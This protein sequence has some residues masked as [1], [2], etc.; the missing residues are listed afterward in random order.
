LIEN[1]HAM[2]LGFE[3]LI[4]LADDWSFVRAFVCAFAFT[5]FTI[6]S[7]HALYNRTRTD[8]STTTQM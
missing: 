1:E 6:T 7:V 4:Y 3:K 5:V 8:I 2:L